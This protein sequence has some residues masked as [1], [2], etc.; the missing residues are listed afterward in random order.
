MSTDR[1]AEILNY[2]SAMSRE[3][4]EFRSETKARFEALEARMDRLEARMDRLESE[5]HEGFKQVREEIRLLGHQI[6]T[7]TLDLMQ[8]RGRQRDHEARISALEAK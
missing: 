1:F 8:V 5:M 6:E 7:M 2:L 3:I 4:G